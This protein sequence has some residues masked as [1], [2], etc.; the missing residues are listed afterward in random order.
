MS[1]TCAT[2]GDG[3]TFVGLGIGRLV[4]TCDRTLEGVKLKCRA[5]IGI[6][7]G[8]RVGTW[9]GTAVGRLTLLY[10]SCSTASCRAGVVGPT[11]GA[12]RRAVVAATAIGTDTTVMGTAALTGVGHTGSQ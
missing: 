12:Q 4:G 5:F 2:L 8:T 3:T 11:G 7:V 10:S 1:A 6:R 9:V